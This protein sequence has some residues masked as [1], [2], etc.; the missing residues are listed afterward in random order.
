MKR[1]TAEYIYTLT[2][3]KPLRNGFVEV[4]DDGTILSVG[5][6]EGPVDPGVIAPGFVNAHCHAE[7]S[8]MKGLFKKGTGMAGFIDQ[9]NA[10]RDTVTPQ[11][12]AQAL[13]EAFDT[14]WEQGVVAMAD[15]SNCADSFALKARH[16]L[17]TRTFLEV[18]GDRPEACGAVMSSVLGLQQEAQAY[19]L[20][21]A[22]TPHSCY[23]M[24]PELLTASSVEGLKSGFLSFHSEESQE[25]E[26][27][28][29]SG[30]GPMWDNRIRNG[31]VPPPV[32]GTTSLEY[33]L[34]RLHAGGLQA[35]VPG[36]VL[37]VHEC[38]LTPEGAALAKAHLE[39]PYMAVCPLSNLFIHGVLPPIEVMRES[40]IPICVGTD[41]L[42]SNDA[43]CIVDELYCLQ[44][45]FPQL[46][47]GELL[48][49]TC[50][51]GA[52]FLRKDAVLGT[53]E[54]GKNPGLVRITGI[55]GEAGNDEA[56]CLAGTG[57]PRLTSS[58]KSIRL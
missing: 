3:H 1:Y 25:E 21:A 8:Y 31:I 12:K 56:S 6:C 10:L 52:R 32:T 2:S 36:H 43:L 26:Q 42:S 55:A 22:P 54:T 30:S 40:G 27:M 19:G 39:H 58:S 33:F 13:E 51:N 18:F 48:E 41:S 37:L 45:A 38:C 5:A 20:D 47:L 28:M 23:T 29:L 34:S 53:I 4:A 7:L 44:Q 46:G 16:P 14:L 11:E 17:Y 35:P 9:I 57:H 15:I 50:L 49:W 24:S